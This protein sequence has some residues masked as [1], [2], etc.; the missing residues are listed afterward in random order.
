[1][2]GGLV[3]I[4]IVMT[5]LCIQSNAKRFL[6][7]EVKKE[8]N[9]ITKDDANLQAVNSGLYGKPATGSV[10]EANNENHISNSS[11]SNNINQDENNESYGKSSNPS[12]ATPDS[13]HIYTGNCKT[14]TRC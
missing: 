2:N 14:R 13:H 5:L 6:L 9:D 12:G 7:E 1:M 4:A 8:K 3:V 10:D 11:A